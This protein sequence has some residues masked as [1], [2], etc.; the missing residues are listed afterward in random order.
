MP[1]PIAI[2]MFTVRDAIQARGPAKVF[3][4]LRTIGYQTVELAGDYGL[5]AAELKAMLDDNGLAVVASHVAYD[6]IRTSLSKVIDNTHTLGH[7]H[8]VCPYLDASL[9]DADGYLGVARTLGEAESHPDAQGL[10]FCYHNHAFEF[11]TLA[12][13]RRGLD[14]IF[15]QPGPSSELDLYW[16]A[17][18]GDDPAVWM[19]R[20]KGRL[21]LVHMKDM[22]ED[23]GFAPVGTGTLD[24][25]KLADLAPSLG[26]QALIVEQDS[27]WPDNDPMLSARISYEH[28]A[29]WV[30]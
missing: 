26:V 17:K 4:E 24:L 13:G 18:G 16:V 19:D 21:P 22:D 7:T 5:P 10:T 28:L 12:D 6:A 9:H 3:D 25:Q 8:V 30:G 23:G 14:I 11:E 1:L 2:Q 20:L 29:Q 15:S 27:G